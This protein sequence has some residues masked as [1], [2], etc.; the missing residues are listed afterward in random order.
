MRTLKTPIIALLLAAVAIFAY[1][2]WWELGVAHRRIAAVTP[3]PVDVGFSQS[4]LLH[5]QQAIAMSQIMLD[6]KPTGLAPLARTI[7]AT[8]LVEYGEMR[9]WLRLWGEVEHVP[10]PDMVWMLLGSKPLDGPLQK[11]VIDCGNSPTGML[12]L[13]TTEDLNALRQSE[14]RA[15]DKRYVELMLKH[16]E[17]GVPMAQF[18]AGE[19]HLAVVRTLASRI[20]MDQSKEIFQMQTLLAALEHQ[21]QLMQE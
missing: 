11:Y 21:P 12:G 17:G 10:Q 6:G 5:H 1:T 19:A 2:Q 9:G 8:Q 20:V 7:A 4:M 14:G 16:H 15:R 18:A 13:A 3:G